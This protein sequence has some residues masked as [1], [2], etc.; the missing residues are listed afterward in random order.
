MFE[1]DDDDGDDMRPFLR[2]VGGPLDG[3]DQ[4]CEGHWVPDSVVEGFDYYA[5]E[6]TA[7]PFLLVDGALV[8]LA[9]HVPTS[10]LRA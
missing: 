10:R 8:H 7:A 6:P 4:R 3:Q 9:R 1:D 5:V 2:F